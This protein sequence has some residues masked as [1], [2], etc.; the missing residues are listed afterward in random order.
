MS[1]NTSYR[2]VPL[3]VLICDPDRSSSKTLQDVLRRHEL[4]LEVTITTTIEEVNQIIE[5]KD[6]NTIFI[7]PLLLGIDEGSNLIFD[8]RKKLPHIVFVLYLDG[9]SAERNRAEFYRGERRRFSHYYTLDKRTP[10]ASFSEELS[11]I[12]NHCGLWLG[13]RVSQEKVRELLKEA[14]RATESVKQLEHGQLLM[15]LRDM[16]SQ[17]ADKTKEEQ[18]SHKGLQKTVFLSHR[19]AEQEYVQGLQRLL[20]QNGFEVTTGKSANTYISK[21]ILDRIN[22]CD[23]FLCLMT[24]G[25]QKSDGTYTTSPWLLEEKGAALAFGKRIV[26]MVEEGVVD[27]GGLQGDWQRIHFGAKGFLNAALEAVKQLKSYTGEQ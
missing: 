17:L 27:I 22:K 1:Y 15:E 24:R 18:V 4:V 10:I 16:L 6:I 20:E 26:L 11:S 7:D 14:E 2:G 5:T 8:I 23:F 25:D 3:K 21:A 13:G 19:F 12:L 9:S